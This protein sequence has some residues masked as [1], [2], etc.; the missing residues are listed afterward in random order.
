MVRRAVQI[1]KEQDRT[2][3]MGY[4]NVANQLGISTQRDT[5]TYHPSWVHRQMRNGDLF[6]ED[7]D[8]SRR[9]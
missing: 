3:M 1:A 4:V 2:N 9:F 7:G 6:G 8:S 5:S